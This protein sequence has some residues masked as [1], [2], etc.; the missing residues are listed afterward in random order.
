TLNAQHVDNQSGLISAQQQLVLNTQGLNNLKGQIISGT[1]LTFV[2]QDLNNQGGLLQ[3]NADLDLNL[4]GVLDN[5][6]AGQLYS[7]GQTTI[8]AASVDNSAQ[9]QI[10]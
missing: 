1:N 8:K 4:S 2:G 5:S 7:G 3:T 6:L 10:N 9:G